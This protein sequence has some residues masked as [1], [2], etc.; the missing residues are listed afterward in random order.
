MIPKLRFPEFIGDWNQHK[1][2]EISTFYNGKA[3]KRS[4]LKATGKYPILRVGN[5][6]TN[7]EWYYSSDELPEHKM[8]ENDDLIYAWSASFGPRIWKGDKVIFHYHIW[9][10]VNDHVLVDKYFLYHLLD[11]ET[12]KM[13]YSNSNGFALLHIT[14]GTIESWPVNIP[15]KREQIKIRQLLDVLDHKIN[16]LTKNKEALETYKKG[17]MQK[18]FSQELRFKRE[19]GTDYPEW[20]N[21]CIADLGEFFNGLTGKNSS[22]FGHGNSQY[23]QYS[24]VFRNSY[25]K[26][27]EC[28]NVDVEDSDK[29]NA[30]KLGDALFTTSSEVAGEV[31]FASIL[32][33][34]PEIDTYLNSFCFGLRLNSLLAPSFAQYLFRTTIFRKAVYP[35]A[36][37]ST[38][39]NVSKK[40]VG[41]VKLLIPSVEEQNYIAKSF[42]IL[43]SKIEQSILLKK[44][45]EQLKKGLLQQ[46][47][48]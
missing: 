2:E 28:D 1:L 32:L 36:Q 7:P 26:L 13:K 24:Q 19:D 10:V 37:G 47:F 43:D 27:D 30:L 42:R 48:V 41:K 25:I 45:T 20:E 44:K 15:N 18:I 5:L 12:A 23:V 6:F 9:K 4:E 8:I 11:I 29:Q 40:E 3:Y 16:L 31:A 33:N 46:M 38:R 35:L 39:Y 34:K 22:H 14:K 17:L 21:Y